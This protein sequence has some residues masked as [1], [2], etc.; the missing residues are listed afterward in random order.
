MLG[1][2]YIAQN[3]CIYS[4]DNGPIEDTG[5]VNANNIQ[6]AKV[7]MKEKTEKL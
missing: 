6:T 2:G 7:I 1:T 3:W 5:K 4:K